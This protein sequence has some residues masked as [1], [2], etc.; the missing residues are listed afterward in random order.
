MVVI[1]CVPSVEPIGFEGKDFAAV[2]QLAAYM[3]PLLLSA[4]ENPQTHGGGFAAGVRQAFPCRK[5]GCCVYT[6]SFCL[7]QKKKRSITEA[8]LPPE[9]TRTGHHLLLTNWIFNVNIVLR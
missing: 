5:A 9:Y 1:F 8:A 7:W 6:A 4:K 2:K 3:Q